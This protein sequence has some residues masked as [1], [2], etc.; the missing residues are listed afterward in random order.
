VLDSHNLPSRRLILL[1]AIALAVISGS[2]NNVFAQ[3]SDQDA[4][5]TEAGSSGKLLGASFVL[6][7]IIP[8]TIGA[9]VVATLLV[10]KKRIK[11]T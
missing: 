1:G 9:A 2:Y 11:K 7:L 3:S 8:I 6:G 4:E 5:Q 10:W